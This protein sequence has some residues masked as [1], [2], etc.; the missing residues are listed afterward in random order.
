MKLPAE[1][2]QVR[3]IRIDLADGVKRNFRKL[4]KET[5]KKLISV[6]ARF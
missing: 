6:V 2:F 1:A 3:C 4:S 5:S